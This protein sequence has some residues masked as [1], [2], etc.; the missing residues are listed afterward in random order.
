M[1][2]DSRMT[3]MGRFKRSC[4]YA[5]VAVVASTI[6]VFILLVWGS[7]TNG[8]NSATGIFY[9]ASY[10][11]GFPLA[12]GWAVST[13]IFGPRGSRAT[14]AQVSGV[15]L[16]PVISMPVDACLPFAV[17]EFFHRKASRGLDS[18]SVLHIKSVIRNGN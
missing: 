2:D 10:V 9:L 4:V 3:S 12:L 18:G 15:F 7:K 13:G 1:T 14:P 5:I 17:W 6:S 11:L 16:T 8:P